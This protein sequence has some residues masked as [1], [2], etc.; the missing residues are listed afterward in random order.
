MDG[1]D[2]S[3]DNSN[4]PASRRTGAVQTVPTYSLYGENQPPGFEEGLHCESIA[5]R[6]RL[7]NW[8]IRTH[9]HELFAQVLVVRAGNGQ[10][11]L[12][13]ISQAIDA[14]CALFVPAHCV[15]GFR[16]SRNIDGVVI[17]LAARWLDRL[18]AGAPDLAARLR[19]PCLLSLDDGTPEW[20]RL[21]RCLQTLMDEWNG[22]GL[23]R[24]AAI[25]AAFSM[26]V[27]ALGRTDGLSQESPGAPVP[28][29]LAHARR[30]RE[31]IEQSF[32]EQ[33]SIRHYAAL[34][35]LTP[36][37]LNRVCRQA[38]GTSALGVLNGRLLTEAKRDLAYSSLS[39]KA[40]A[41]TLG[42]S[43][44]A[45]FTRLFTRHT[46]RSPTAFREEARRQL[47]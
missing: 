36:T 43:D 34:L 9:R 24:D 29:S 46:G 20:V 31:L 23:W 27:I 2:N 10:A 44:A 25:E 47:A 8:E 1:I 14:P 41:L 13:G 3:L 39:V 12:D 22:T 38:L 19:A 18:L 11:R 4:I 30:Y 37:Q 7:Y 26:L 35:G 5:E 40:I 32:R 17:T 42:F 28:R 15:H 21:E 16:F 45:Y 6:S 33:R